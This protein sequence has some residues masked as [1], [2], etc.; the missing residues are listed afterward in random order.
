MIFN[1][2]SRTSLLSFSSHHLP[3]AVFRDLD[4]CTSLALS[5]LWPHPLTIISGCGQRATS[6]LDS[7][8]HLS[9]VS[10]CLCVVSSPLQ[11][12]HNCGWKWH[13][14]KHRFWQVS[15]S[16]VRDSGD[17]ESFSLSQFKSTMCVFLRAHVCVCVCERETVRLPVTTFSLSSEC[18]HFDLFS[19]CVIVWCEII[20][21]SCVN[22]IKQVSSPLLSSVSLQASFLLAVDGHD[23]IVHLQRNE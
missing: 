16:W 7:L 11:Q 22:E 20:C 23:H 9:W 4:K 15:A 12:L 5:D 14:H 10:G 18:F 6:C 1:S 21:L 3:L 13:T 2:S 17:L 19:H 8:R